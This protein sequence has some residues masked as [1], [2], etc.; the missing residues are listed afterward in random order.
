MGKIRDQIVDSI[1]VKEALVKGEGHLSVIMEIAKKIIE[2][3]Q[4]GGKVIF[5]GNGGSAADSQHLACEFVSKFQMERRALQSIALSVNTSILTA[6]GNDYD[7]DRVFARQIEAWA[8]PEDV[9][10]GISTSGNSSNVVA[11]IEKAKEI[12]AV[13]VAF[14][15][16]G[17]G[18][19]AP[20]VDICFKTPSVST[21]RIQEAHITVGHI[22]CDIVEKAI[23]D[24][25]F[26]GGLGES[27][28]VLPGR[29]SEE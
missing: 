14:T 11:A 22:I 25:S 5:M 15:G 28:D 12:G 24:E 16:E 26:L 6:I 9:V 29:S 20:M 19:L 8:R 2:C 17:G 13:T 10:V 7:F 3:Y 27:H 18:K 21:P 4:V 23:F 1:S